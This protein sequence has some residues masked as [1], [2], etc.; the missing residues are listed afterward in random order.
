MHSA[1]LSPGL[2]AAIWLVMIGVAPGCDRI[3]LVPG[4]A[5][6]VVD[7]GPADV[8][9]IDTGAIGSDGTPGLADI[10]PPVEATPSN[11]VDSTDDKV[12]QL[13]TKD[14]APDGQESDCLSCDLL[15]TNMLD[16]PDASGDAVGDAAAAT[17][18]DCESL[19][20]LCGG[21]FCS[22]CQNFQLDTSLHAY[23]EEVSAILGPS[24]L[25]NYMNLNYLSLWA[26]AKLELTGP[27][28][29]RLYGTWL[30]NVGGQATGF[31]AEMVSC[32]A[33]CST[34]Q[35]TKATLLPS[36]CVAFDIDIDSGQATFV[37]LEP[38][39]LGAFKSSSKSYLKDVG[40]AASLGAIPSGKPVTL[41]LPDGRKLMAHAGR[42]SVHAM[43][44]DP[45]ANISSI[46]RDVDGMALPMPVTAGVV[47]IAPPQGGTPTT[48]DIEVSVCHA[49]AAQIAA[50][51]CV[52]P[53]VEF[54]KSVPS[55]PSEFWMAAASDMLDVTMTSAF[56]SAT[57]PANW[58]G[59]GLPIGP[60]DFS[61]DQTCCKNCDILDPKWTCG[62]WLETDQALPVVAM[63]RIL[64]QHWSRAGVYLPINEI[65]D[66]IGKKVPFL[67][68]A[69][70]SGKF[71]IASWL[72]GS[73]L[74]VAK[75]DAAWTGL[76][77]DNNSQLLDYVVTEWG[78]Q[79]VTLKA[80]SPKTLACRK[81]GL[82]KLWEP[83]G[84][85]NNLC[86]WTTATFS[87]HIDVKKPGQPVP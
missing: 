65:T 68:S 30:N 27:G 80:T 62:G 1:L 63:A 67:V 53:A 87:V 57:E 7:G 9:E 58:Q 43:L 56:L 17:P 36:G 70:T 40:C 46:V 41:V 66:P 47:E 64:V 38:T 74:P 44:L 24:I 19:P 71:A 35:Y 2:S 79:N 20:V 22:N 8:A 60:Y 59:V 28:H 45:E 16:G 73:D 29:A 51:G 26:P 11:Q 77:A 85:A 81:L 37:G 86:K 84:V 48:V 42:A 15:D 69:K 72:L 78:P 31:K 3:R 33:M 52:C 23:Q 82:G 32:I 25:P 21:Q 50:S 12:D 61:W 39:P 55:G 75:R 54:P 14:A 83:A 10:A 76:Y 5:Q 6:P 4:P 34:C 13:L 18:A 49:T